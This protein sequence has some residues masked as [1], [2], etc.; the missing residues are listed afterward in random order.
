LLALFNCAGNPPSLATPK[1]GM[2]LLS[3]L[4]CLP[5]FFS[6]LANFC[7]GPLY[8]QMLQRPFDFRKPPFFFPRFPLE[9]LLFCVFPG[10]AFLFLTESAI[11]ALI[12]PS[13]GSLAIMSVARCFSELQWCCWRTFPPSLLP[14]QNYFGATFVSF[15]DFPEAFGLFSLSPCFSCVSLQ[16]FFFVIRGSFSQKR[17]LGFGSPPWVGASPQLS[18]SDGGVFPEPI[19][20]PSIIYVA[21]SVFFFSSE[22]H[23]SFA[24][25]GETPLCEPSLAV[26]F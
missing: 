5:F 8:P 3:L 4:D 21:G 25:L 12:P 23:G 13:F 9:T 24:D 11:Q 20:S 15:F 22:N 18:Q 19:V 2:D 16:P 14:C 6:Q 1:K 26:P 7:G 17:N 10:D